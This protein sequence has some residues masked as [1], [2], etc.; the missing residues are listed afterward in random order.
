MD[1]EFSSNLTNISINN[2]YYLYLI[3]INHFCITPQIQSEL[4][5][6]KG[7]KKLFSVLCCKPRE[8]H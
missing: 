8:V 6:E 1:A 7:E 3:I 4:Y 2:F 5:T